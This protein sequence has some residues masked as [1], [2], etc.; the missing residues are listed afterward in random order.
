[1]HVASLVTS[2]LK[3]QVRRPA[4]AVQA[5]A[6]ATFHATQSVRTKTDYPGAKERGRLLIG[7]GGRDGMN[8]IRTHDHI[9]GVAAVDVV[10]REARL[11]T[12]VFGTSGA[13]R[14]DAIGE[15]QPGN[16]HT[17]ARAYVPASGANRINLPHNLMPG[18]QWAFEKRQVTFHDMQVGPA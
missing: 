8:E 12:Q 4:E 6:L 2:Q 11:L 13:V 10:S 15:V 17:L 5:K 3:H 1:M 18:N 14:A 16:P 9:V 7:K